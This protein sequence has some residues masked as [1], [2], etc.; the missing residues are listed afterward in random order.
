MT[1]NLPV[2]KSEIE[3]SKVLEGNIVSCI[4]LEVKDENNQS[5]REN[6]KGY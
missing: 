1:E 4:E 5:Q 6:V 2:K 3:G